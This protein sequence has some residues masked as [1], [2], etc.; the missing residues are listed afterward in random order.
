MRGPAPEP[1][2]ACQG[3]SSLWE[4]RDVEGQAG[5]KRPRGARAQQTR[6]GNR[7]GPLGCQGAAKRGRS[8]ALAGD[9]AGLSL[10]VVSRG[11]AQRPSCPAAPLL[12]TE[13]PSLP[14]IAA[15][16]P[17]DRPC[18]QVPWGLGMVPF[19]RMGW[20]EWGTLTP[21]SARVRLPPVGWLGVG[22]TAEGKDS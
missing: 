4:A 6:W 10:A 12:P 17:G 7:V 21:L 13:M 8:W 3:R 19:F 16:G 20:E 18:P 15:C 1:D 14:P 9:G 5:Q 22:S 2:A 11:P